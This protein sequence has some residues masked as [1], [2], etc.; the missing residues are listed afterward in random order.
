MQIVAGIGILCGLLFTA[1]QVQIA[2]DQSIVERQSKSLEHLAS[3]N[4]ALRVAGV[5][6]LAQLAQNSEQA[7]SFAFSILESFIEDRVSL[8]DRVARDQ[9]MALAENAMTS[10]NDASR[11]DRLAMWRFVHSLVG[12]SIG[13]H[14]FQHDKAVI[15][16]KFPE[17]TEELARK[18]HDLD[19]PHGRDVSHAI[20]AITKVRDNSSIAPEFLGLY[21]RDADYR[22][23]RF[24][25]WRVMSSLFLT[26]KFN[27]ASLVDARLEGI[28]FHG[29][30]VRKV[31]FRETELVNVSFLGCRLEGAIFDEDNFKGIAMMSDSTIEEKYSERLMEIAPGRLVLSPSG[32]EPN[33]TIVNDSPEWREAHVIKLPLAPSVGPDLG[34]AT[35]PE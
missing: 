33:R 20:S 31:D 16:E 6:E 23:H 22:D 30:D 2:T 28:E 13:Y 25:Q 29:C 35:L 19:S 26:S 7:R 11:E 27:G 1:S 15:Q 12:I 34:D 3:E 17:V 32:I 4:E 18:A 21:L 8:H 10:R 14:G 9:L 5:F 24:D